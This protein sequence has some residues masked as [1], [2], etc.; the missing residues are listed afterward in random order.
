MLFCTLFLSCLSAFST[1]SPAK[2]F[3]KNQCFRFPTLEETKKTYKVFK[4]ILYYAKL[5]VKRNEK[6]ENYMSKSAVPFLGRGYFLCGFHAD[7]EQCS[8][9]LKCKDLF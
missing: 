1:K 9:K 8:V 3:A 7:G 4:M 2:I 6:R 5:K